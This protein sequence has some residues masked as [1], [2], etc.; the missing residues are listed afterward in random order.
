MRILEFPKNFLWGSSTASYQVE[1]GIENNDWAAAARLGKVPVAGSAANHYNLYDA[2]FKLAKS[3]GHNSHRIS[4]E[5]SRIEPEEGKFDLDEID[6][7]RRVLKSM[8]ENGLKPMVTLWHF[9]LP[10]WFA[11]KGG[12]NHPDSPE[13]FARYCFYVVNNLHEYNDH[14]DSINEPMVWLSNGN[15]VGKWPP[16][17]KSLWTTINA[18]Y[19]LV[20]AHNLAYAQI[21]KRFPNLSFGVVKHN[22]WFTSDKMPWNIIRAKCADWFWNKIFLRRLK[23]NFDHLGLNYYFHSQYGK[24]IQFPKSDFGWDLDAE[25]LYHCLKGLKKYNKP[26]YVTEAGLSDEFDT[27][28]AWYIEDLVKWSHQA[29][30]D[31]VMLKGFSYWSFVDNFEWAEGYKQKFGLIDLDFKTKE[32]IPRK[33]AFFYKNICESNVLE[34]K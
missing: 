33:S 4:I 13:I 34:I 21:K 1:G 2:D 31:G 17:K 3:L 24:K 19:N 12:F 32:R 8:H 20:S 27:N 7:Y 23:N 29:L 28:R 25:G 5:W 11:K 30:E 6:H 18:F 26:V 15:L 22:I 10:E 9:T 14:W 16:F